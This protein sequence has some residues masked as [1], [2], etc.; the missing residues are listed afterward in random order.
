MQMDDL[1]MRLLIG[2]LATMKTIELHEPNAV[3][4]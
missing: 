1:L 3:M 4:F 2:Y